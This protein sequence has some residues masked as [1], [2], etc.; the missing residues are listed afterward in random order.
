MKN[1]SECDVVVIGAGAA[2]LAA[3][4]ELIKHKK[5]VICVEAMDRIG[6]RCFTDN[7][8]FDQPFDVGAHWLHSYSNNQIAHFGQT[9][10]D[11][12][13]IYK[14]DEKITVYEGNTKSDGKE[15]IEIISGAESL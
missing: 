5:S 8:I 2:G 9:K 15:L 10:K 13:E 1:I 6:G 12:F 11:E 3:T 4:A 7:K 14:I